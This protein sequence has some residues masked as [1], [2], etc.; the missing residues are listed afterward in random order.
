MV[1]AVPELDGFHAS[2]GWL[3][4]FKMS[5]G[6][7]ESTTTTA[8]EAGDAPVTTV[9]AWMKRFPELKKC[10]L[11]GDILNMD[12]LGL[13]INTL[14]QKGLVEKGKKS[15]GGKQRKNDAPLHFSWLLMT[16]RLVTLLWC[17]DPKNIVALKT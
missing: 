13:T 3:E 7:R 15:R 2:N 9:K 11:T 5:Y 17:E 6:I 12:E 16:L 8:G 1:E 14:P 10:Y 4:S